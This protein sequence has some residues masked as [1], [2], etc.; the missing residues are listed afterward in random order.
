MFQ[1]RTNGDTVQVPAVV[2]G[3]GADNR[4]IIS[5]DHIGEFVF[6]TESIGP[7]RS[8]PIGDSHVPDT[9]RDNHFFYITVCGSAA[10]N[11]LFAGNLV[12]QL[13]G[14]DTFAAPFCIK[15]DISLDCECFS[16][17]V[18]DACTIRPGVPPKEKPGGTVGSGFYLYRLTGDISGFIRWHISCRKAGVG[19]VY[20]LISPRNR[21]SC[22]PWC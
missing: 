10:G 20:D 18:S 2:K 4:N 19:F 5:N 12:D 3:S 14:G 16:R 8:D 15:S 9:G 22:R 17:L 1:T 6:S 7:H 11:G 21:S 13:C